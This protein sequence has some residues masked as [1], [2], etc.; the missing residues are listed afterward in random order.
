VV[1]RTGERDWSKLQELDLKG[2]FK[3]T[4]IEGSSETVA[5]IYLTAACASENAFNFGL[6]H[7][8]GLVF[9]YVP[10]QIF[11]SEFKESLCL[12][13]PNLFAIADRNYGYVKP[14]GSTVTGMVDC[15]ASFSYFGCLEFF[16]IAYIMQRLYRRA[17]DGNIIAQSLYLFMMTNALHAITHGTTWFVSPWVH[18]LVFWIPLMFYATRRSATIPSVLFSKLSLYS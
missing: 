18:M 14:T 16:I 9:N 2:T 17:I 13:I 11:G 1:S 5:G 12:P 4:T 6:N 15:F 7:W 8:N 10:A 3:K